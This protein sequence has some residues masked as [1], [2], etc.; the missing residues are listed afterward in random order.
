MTCLCSEAKMKN[1]YWSISNT[2]LLT[3]QSEIEKE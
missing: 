1:N 2:V 3:L